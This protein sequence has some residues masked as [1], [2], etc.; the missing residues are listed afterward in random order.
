[1][2]LP[3]QPQTVTLFVVTGVAPVAHSQVVIKAPVTLLV[4]CFKRKV[5]AQ[6]EQTLVPLQV[7]Q[8][9]TLHSKHLLVSV[10]SWNP[11]LHLVQTPV[12]ETQPSSAQF[13]GQSTTQLPE[14][15]LYPSLHST[16]WL[17]MLHD[18]QF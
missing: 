6:L 3:L 8:F 16:H 1:M 2:K 7:S 4:D 13:D 14:T 11:V 12:T 5:S 17:D 9:S 15:A 10:L 18:L